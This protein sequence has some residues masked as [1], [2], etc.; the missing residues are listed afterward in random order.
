[1]NDCDVRHYAKGFCRRHYRQDHVHGDP[2]VIGSTFKGDE[3]TYSGAHMRVI[4][5]RG[6]ASQHLC[7][8]GRQAKDWSYDHKDPNE[9]IQQYQHKQLPF[10]PDPAHYIPLCRFCHRKLDLEAKAK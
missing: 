9:K 5:E 6:P 10:S 8:C 4:R 3:I 1:M 7:G 2:E